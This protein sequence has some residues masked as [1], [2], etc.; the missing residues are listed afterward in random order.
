[1]MCDDRDHGSPSGCRL[2]QRPQCI[3][4]MLWLAAFTLPLQAAWAQD[5][6][7]NRRR[8]DI[9]G[10]LKH[11]HTMAFADRAEQLTATDLVHH[12]LNMRLDLNDRL[13]MRLGMRNRLFLGEGVRAVPDF[14]RSIDADTG[15]VRMSMRWLD[16]PGIALLTT[17]E[18]AVVRLATNRWMVDV[19]RQRINWG[20]NTVWNP[21]DLFNAYNFLDFDHEERPGRDALRVQYFPSATRAIDLA[22]APGRT[23]SGH[24]GALRYGFSHRRY[25]MQVLAGLYRTDVVLGAGWAGNIS[26]AGFKGEAAWFAPRDHGSDSAGVFT[27]SFTLDRTF[28]REWYLSAAYLYNSLGDAGALSGNVL[29]GPAISARRLLP[30]Q[31]TVHLGCMKSFSPVTSFSL[32]LVHAPFRS[33]TILFPTFTYSAAANFELDLTLQSFFADNGEAWATRSNAFYLRLRWSY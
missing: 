17:F 32:A 2:R 3:R 20:I 14:A 29:T 21:N 1:M 4:A 22:F 27:A 28:P 5:T 13:S 7:A 12:R 8:P 6:T 11:L 16:R 18:R 23:G 26:D 33:S 15:V 19:G 30:F 31:H 9:S 25:D 10:Y 24:I